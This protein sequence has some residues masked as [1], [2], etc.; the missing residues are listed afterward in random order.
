MNRRQ[1]KGLICCCSVLYEEVSYLWKKYWPDWEIYALTSMLH[2][3]P[4]LLSHQLDECINQERKAG[5]LVV[6]VYGDCCPLMEQFEKTPGVARTAA[7]NCCEL[8][9]GKEIYKPLIKEGVFFLLPE[10]TGRWEEIFTGELG[11][12]RENARDFMHEMHTR[13][14]FLDTGVMPVPVPDIEACSRHCDLPY[15]IRQTPL[16][17]LQSSIQGAMN[18]LSGEGV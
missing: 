8:V 3:R 15:E 9:L 1:N 11:L 4:D 18:R 6:L 2:M 12:S 5:N 14:I 7:V 13:L 16:D 17:H 10:W